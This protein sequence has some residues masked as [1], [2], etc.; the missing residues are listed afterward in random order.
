TTLRHTA[1]IASPAGQPHTHAAIEAVPG[2]HYETSRGEGPARAIQTRALPAAMRLARPHGRRSARGTPPAGPARL[3]T[4]RGVRARPPR[5]PKSVA[6]RTC[7]RAPAVCEP[8]PSGP[9]PQGFVV[10]RCA[11][12]AALPCRNV[13]RRGS[14]QR[15]RLK[16]RRLT[17]AGRLGGATTRTTRSA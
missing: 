5:G 17:G 10:R 2:A 16:C 12:R 4:R 3:V 15:A 11:A 13:R 14:G 7:P 8:G 9:A 6:H 1:N